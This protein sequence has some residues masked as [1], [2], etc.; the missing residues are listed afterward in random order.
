MG[1]NSKGQFI[2]GTGVV[3]KTGEVFG[4]LTVLRRSDR[5]SGRKTY[6]VCQ[7]ECGNIKEVRSDCLGIVNSCGCLKRE[8]NK[9]NLEA[10]HR[11][12]L[13]G[14]RLYNEWQCIKRR[15]LN[16]NDK[17]YSDYG[18]RGIRLCDEWLVPDNFFEWAMA[19]GYRDDLTIDRVN[20]N[21][22]YE[23]SNCRWVDNKTQ[24][25]N[26]RSNILINYCGKVQT[27]KQWCEELNINYK[28]SW[29]RYKRGLPLEK[30]FFDG[31]LR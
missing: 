12:K 9:I 24:S 8:Q 28:R 1:R 7:C 30:V 15:C 31:D 13:S 17:R 5:K 11:H 26:K 21:C 23:P 29:D 3:D 14:T 18:G 10:N 16:K 20:N 25:N 22:D 6:W 4:R 19:N 2:K 27:L